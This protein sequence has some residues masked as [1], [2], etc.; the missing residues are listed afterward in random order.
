MYVR[1]Y[2]FY[3][4]EGDAIRLQQCWCGHMKNY[5]VITTIYIIKNFKKLKREW[6]LALVLK[7]YNVENLEGNFLT[8]S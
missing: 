4:K 7:N 6:R 3:V 2:L 1:M 8:D 5:K